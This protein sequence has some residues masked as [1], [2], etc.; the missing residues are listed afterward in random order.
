MPWS[1]PI[2]DD[3]KVLTD[4]QVYCMIS[5]HEHSTCHCYTEQA[6]PYR[7]RL[8]DVECRSMAIYGVYDPYRVAFKSEERDRDRESPKQG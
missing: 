7:E 4:P 6:T 5:G 8:D 2:Y 3:R 1:A